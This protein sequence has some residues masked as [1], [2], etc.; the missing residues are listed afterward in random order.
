MCGVC[1]EVLTAV[2][3]GLKRSRSPQALN[4][5]NK[6]RAFEN[7]H[8]RLPRPVAQHPANAKPPCSAR[9]LISAL[10]DGG[11]VALPPNVASLALVKA[12][13]ELVSQGLDLDVVSSWDVIRAIQNP[14]FRL[15]GVRE[16][17]S[18]DKVFKAHLAAV[19]RSIGL[20]VDTKVDA[21]RLRSITA[22]AERC[23]AAAPVYA[24]HRDTWYGCPQSLVIAWIPLHDVTA[25]EVFAFYPECF[26]RPV[27][28]T[29]R[30]HDHRKWMQDVGWHGTTSPQ[31][32]AE[33]EANPDAD[34]GSTLRWD[35]KAGTI[36]LFS[37]A[38]LHQTLPNP[39]DG[40]T[41][42]SLDFRIL[43]LCDSTAPN[44]DNESSGE[45]TRIDAEFWL[46]RNVPT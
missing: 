15:G 39:T 37:A 41:R 2:D 13:G 28:N 24:L 31:N 3:V 9:N 34:L 40:N 11:I 26:K 17:L 23:A 1:D 22:G 25:D 32:F 14:Y 45:Q 43:P 36:L 5:S 18:K 19:C 16:T 10:H 29:S 4:T 6:A 35:L 46:V 44:V 27:P 42:Y 12:S 30:K 20:W 38:Q 8:V 33:A 21:P 7:L